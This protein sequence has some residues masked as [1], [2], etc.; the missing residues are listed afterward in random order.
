MDLT[1]IDEWLEAGGHKITWFCP[2]TLATVCTTVY[3]EQWVFGK[4]Y[5]TLSNERKRPLEMFE[6]S[7]EDNI[8]MLSICKF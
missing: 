6:T 3:A 5:V 2:S 8:E 7:I 4:H 1:G